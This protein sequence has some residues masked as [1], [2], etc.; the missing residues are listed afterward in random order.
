MK[1]LRANHLGAWYPFSFH[2]YGRIDL[3]VRPLVSGEHA[4]SEGDTNH[5]K[6]GSAEFLAP[7]LEPLTD[8]LS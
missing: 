2:I 1:S 5:N 3:S 4:N 7:L 6:D 8:P